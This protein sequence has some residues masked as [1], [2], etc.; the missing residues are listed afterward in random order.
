LVFYVFMILEGAV[1]IIIIIIIIK[2]RKLFG[3][4]ERD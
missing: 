2:A 1:T 4:K 3:E